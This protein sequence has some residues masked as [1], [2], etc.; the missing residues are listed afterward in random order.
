MIAPERATSY[1]KQPTRNSLGPR[2]LPG[3]GVKN[4]LGPAIQTL[5]FGIVN[6]PGAALAAAMTVCC[7]LNTRGANLLRARSTTV[8][9]VFDT[10]HKRSHA[11]LASAGGV[12][13]RAPGTEVRYSSSPFRQRYIP[14]AGWPETR[15]SKL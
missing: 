15:S 14:P 1:R 9:L 6:A 11:G 12:H 8:G 13:Y 5:S 3:A 10:E 7:F 2:A 4:G